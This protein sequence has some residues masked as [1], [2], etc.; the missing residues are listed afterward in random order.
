MKACAVKL[1][2]HWLSMS[3]FESILFKHFIT[4][5]Y[6][7]SHQLLPA[8]TTHEH[9]RYLWLYVAAGVGRWSSS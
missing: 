6:K 7:H 5:N 9:T 1:P 8:G 3:S 4:E 2:F